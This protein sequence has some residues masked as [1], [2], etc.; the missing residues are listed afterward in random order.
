MITDIVIKVAIQRHRIVDLF[1][2]EK[3]LYPLVGIVIFSLLSRYSGSNFTWIVC[4]EM[5]TDFNLP[6]S[7][8]WNQLYKEGNI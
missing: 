4:V 7:V 3:A 1:Q 8:K 5:V 6:I 2:V